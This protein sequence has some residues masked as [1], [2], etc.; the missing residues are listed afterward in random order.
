[1]R[2]RIED[3]FTTGNKNTPL[4]LN[5]TA[6]IAHAKCPAYLLFIPPQKTAAVAAINLKHHFLCVRGFS[7][8]HEPG[9]S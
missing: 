1:M 8:I 3:Q 4:F 9:A 7:D 6:I 5:M 2:W